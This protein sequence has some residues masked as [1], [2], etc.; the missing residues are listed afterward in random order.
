MFLMSAMTSLFHT[1]YPQQQPKEL[2]VN[3]HHSIVDLLK[4]SGT[5]HSSWILVVVVLVFIAAY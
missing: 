1:L 3:Y 2:F 4:L 5:M